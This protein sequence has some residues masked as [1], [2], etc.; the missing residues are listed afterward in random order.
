MSAA[1]RETEELA[2]ADFSHLWHPFTQQREWCSE[3]PLVIVSGTGALLTD[4]RGRSYIDGNSSIWTNIHG[5]SHPRIIE[6]VARQLATLDHTSFLG[7]THP[8]A[9][10]L[11]VR[12]SG[13]FPGSPLPRVFFSDNGSTAVEAALKMSIQYWQQRG[14]PLRRRFAS[15]SNAYHGD[16]A[17]A[18]S[19]GGIASFF[20]RFAGMHF[21]VERFADMEELCAF[22]RPQELA[23]VVI[24]PIIQGVAGMQPWPQGMLR[25]LRSYCNRTGTLLILDEVMTAFGRTGTMFACQREEVVPDLLCCA[26]GLTGGVLPL[27]ATLITEEIYSAFLGTHEEQKTFQ[28]GHSY[29]A[30]PPACAAALANLSLFE[31]E[32]T[33]E[34]LQPKIAH[35]EN[36]LK[37]L[38]SIPW[39][40]GIRQCGF[41][42][43]IEVMKDPRSLTPFPWQHQTGAMICKAARKHGLLT[44][45][46]RD[47]LVLMP[48]LCITMEQIDLAIE[49][50]EK[51]ILE[52]CG[53][54]FVPNDQR[55]TPLT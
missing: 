32:K 2:A 4:S 49:A 26:K 5:H 18:S 44:R 41:I 3:E 39:V 10:R 22:S 38:R 52:V 36:R 16:T 45:P 31:E 9:I 14:N 11:A 54:E 51:A 40:A 29:T 1:G 24:E 8:A 30:N 28:Y 46:V 25:E 33:L 23:A 20:D 55:G 13:L 35:L 47:T 50:L 27:A 15:F 53:Q 17:G 48:P 19:L 7:T 43:G 34:R 21:P 12:L 6:A 42:A 37:S